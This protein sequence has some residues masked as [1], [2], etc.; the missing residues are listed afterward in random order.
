MTRGFYSPASGISAERL[1]KRLGETS[2]RNSSYQGPGV[3]TREAAGPS[4]RSDRLGDALRAV[5]PVLAALTSGDTTR[6]LER[7]L[8]RHMGRAPAQ[9]IISEAKAAAALRSV[10][11]HGR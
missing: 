4:V 10:S 9:T 6:D 7:E 1:A 3:G 8:R 5:C 2:R 11:G